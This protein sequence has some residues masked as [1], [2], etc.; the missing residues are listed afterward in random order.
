MAEM[1][2]TIKLFG[3]ELEMTDVPIKKSNEPW[4]E[5]ELEDGSI[6]KFKSV[7]SSV[8]RVVG[9]YSPDGNPVYIVVS[10]PVNQVVS[11]PETLHR[12]DN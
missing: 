9:Q 7:A 8:L 11:S 5:Y 1:K 3:R 2:R 12:K 10:A 4:S 6:V